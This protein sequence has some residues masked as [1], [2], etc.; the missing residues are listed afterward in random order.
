MQELELCYFIKN[1]DFL[2]RGSYTEA[3][4]KGMKDVRRISQHKQIILSWREKL[5]ILPNMW[6][7]K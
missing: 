7:D 2:A 5:H 6:S 3:N 4:F 1:I